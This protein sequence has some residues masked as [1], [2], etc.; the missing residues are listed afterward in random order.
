MYG[1]RY[2]SLFAILLAA[3]GV[4]VGVLIYVIVSQE[5][6]KIVHY[7][8]VISRQS[9]AQRKRHTVK[10]MKHRERRARTG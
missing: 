9:R 8:W 4:R 6:N 1:S 10:E 3:S 7:Y 2:L 5:A